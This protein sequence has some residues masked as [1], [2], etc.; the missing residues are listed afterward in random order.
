M[1]AAWDGRSRHKQPAPTLPFG[2]GDDVPADPDPLNPHPE[3]P[4]PIELVTRLTKSERITRVQR[5][6]EMAWNR[7]DQALDSIKDKNVAGVCSLVSG[8]NDSYTVAHLFRGVSTTWVHANTGTGIE[9]TREHVR[10]TAAAWEIPLLEVSGT[11]G[12][13]YF[14]LVRGEVYAISRETGELVQTWGGG[15][16]GS[17]AH[18]LQYQRLK[19]R[20]LEKVPHHFGISGSKQDRVVFIAGRRRSESKRRAT[21][22]HF[23]EQGTTLWASPI[24]VW[25]KADLRAYRLLHRDVPVNPVAQILGMSGECGCLANATHNEREQWFAAYPDEPFILAIQALEEELKPRTDIPE[26]R[27]T[28]GWGSD[29]EAQAAEAEYLAE[30]RK[31]G[32]EPEA[33]EFSSV[34]LCGP[35]CGPDPIADG[36]DFLF[37]L[38]GAA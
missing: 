15:F 19:Q 16:P 25:H 13:G 32:K 27:K 7:Y 5:L 14:D 17:A 21:V 10:D 2:L 28:W 8:G 24:A 4:T 35:N 1:T 36:M 6:T 31:A 29:P 3:H 9:A 37:D 26:H 30:R 22:P 12:Q 33:V 20:A 34:A 11:P 18:A 38:D 23:E